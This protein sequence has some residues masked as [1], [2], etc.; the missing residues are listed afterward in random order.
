[1]QMI[2]KLMIRKLHNTEHIGICIVFEEAHIRKAATFS[3]LPVKV[4]F[5]FSNIVTLWIMYESSSSTRGIPTYI[6]VFTV[7][8]SILLL[9]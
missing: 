4:L 5:V 7:V 3:K 1:M 2:L 6:I 9:T 8:L